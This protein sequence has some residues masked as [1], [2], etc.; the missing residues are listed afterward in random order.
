M[1]QPTYKVFVYG[2][3]MKGARNEG[4]LNG[5][6]LIASDALTK[7][8]SYLMLQFNSSSS[9]GKQTPAVKKGGQGFVQG[10]IYEVDQAGL[11]ALD[12]LE[13]NGVRYQREEVEMQ[14]RSTAWMYILIADDEPSLQQDRINFNPTT[15]AYSWK[16]EDPRP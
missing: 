14:D 4:L 9:P 2:T 6:R 16:R 12:Q 13:Q 11:D 10:E 3:L 7:E 5:A 15:K 8:D 1:T